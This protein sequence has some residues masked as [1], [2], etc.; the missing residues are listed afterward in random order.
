MHLWSIIVPL[1]ACM[2]IYIYMLVGWQGDMKRVPTV[3]G[4]MTCMN[5]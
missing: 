4:H 5:G 3:T 1:N 2:C